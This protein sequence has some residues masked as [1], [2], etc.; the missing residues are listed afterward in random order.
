[1]IATEDKAIDPRLLRDTA[2]RIGAV[3]VEVPASH[4][5]FLTRPGEVADVIDTAARASGGS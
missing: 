3:P 2:E 4:V 5:V 1:M